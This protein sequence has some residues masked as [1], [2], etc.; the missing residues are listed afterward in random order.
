[1]SLFEL[2]QKEIE[3]SR[4]SQEKQ[5]IFWETYCQKEK[6]VYEDLLGKKEADIQGSISDFAKKYDMTPVEIV[7]FL[8]GISE[9]L[10][11]EM[12]DLST[13]TEDS[14]FAFTIDFEK[15]FWN[16]LAVPAEWLFTLPQWDGVLS[17]EKREEIFKKFKNRN[18][19]VKEAKIG[20]N[21][22]CPCGSG[23]KYKKCCGK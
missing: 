13:L 16:M 20:R 17:Q 21:D 6:G 12:V 22:P 14:E 19:I 18:T 7:G 1:M 2:W 10:S 11:T 15:L 3:D 4:E 5:E 9:S 23:K 8:D